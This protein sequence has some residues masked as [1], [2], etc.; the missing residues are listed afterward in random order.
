MKSLAL[1]YRPRKF[2]DVSGQAYIVKSLKNVIDAKHAAHA[3]LFFGCRGIGKTSIA[4][5]VAR[6]LNCLMGPTSSP[7]GTCDNCADISNGNSPD[8]IEMDAASN[9]GIQYIRELREN[10]KFAPMKSRYKVYIID[11]AHMLTNESF[12]ALLKTLEEPPPHV[13]FILATTEKH[14]I[15][16]TILSRC[17][18]FSFKKFTHEQIIER[19]K[20]I[21]SQE[22][23][24]FEESALMLI[25]QK[26]EGSMRDAISCL[27]QV[28][29]Y[30]LEKNILTQ[31]VQEILGIL[32]FEVYCQILSFIRTNDLNKLLLVVEKSHEEGYHLRDFLWNFLDIV[33]SGY[34]IKIKNSAEK[35]SL[36]SESQYKMLEEEVALW[37]AEILQQTFYSFY[38][39]YAN[40]MIFQGSGNN[41]I[42]ISL[43]M[44]MVGL[45]QKL[46]QPS[47]SKLTQK[48]AQL[49]NAIEKGE[50][51]Q[52]T[53]QKKPLQQK[54][55]EAPTGNES[56]NKAN[57]EKGGD[58][59]DMDSV[60][61]KEFM[62]QQDASKEMTQ[63]FNIN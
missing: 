33:K 54:T 43:E 40:P 11:E 27:D 17:Q 24:S 10:T 19:L 29:A 51:F 28:L 25:A 38:E 26:A 4:R 49:K 5:I 62:G 57:K 36:L 9:R 34:L 30:S 14:K 46:Q 50:N 18:N 23:I 2:E 15:P 6:S 3:Y 22:D 52:D 12:N 55:P 42:R 31:E 8:V 41:E 63:L 32:P 35:G 59:L 16:E 7:C 47:V 56:K 45:M 37:D 44:A 39:V 58:E 53:S 60:I 61:Q 20:F 1:K 48:I 13:V 21:L